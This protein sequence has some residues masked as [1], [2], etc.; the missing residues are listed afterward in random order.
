MG[1]LATTLEH[2]E[3]AERHFSDALR[4]HQSWKWWLYVP[5]TQYGWALMLTRRNLS[6][7]R[8]Q[9]LDLLDSAL[10]RASNINV[11]TAGARGARRRGRGYTST[12]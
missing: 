1:Q 2:W 7:D 10:E 4:L 5:W 12:T 3:N 11:I 9:A 8:Y 6:G